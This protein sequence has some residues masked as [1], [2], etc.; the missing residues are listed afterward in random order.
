M[1][2][3]ETAAAHGQTDGGRLTL[4]SELELLLAGLKREGVRGG[5]TTLLV[6]LTPTRPHKPHSQLVVLGQVVADVTRAE[7]GGQAALAG[8]VATPTA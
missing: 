7:R 8:T 4:S 5:A 1:W 2:V 3:C 6:P